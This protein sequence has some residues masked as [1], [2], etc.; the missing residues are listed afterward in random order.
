MGYDSRCY[1]L[2]E[3]FVE[4]D[5]LNAGADA[6]ER[7]KDELAQVIQSAIEDYLEDVQ[8]D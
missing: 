2:A 8:R 3:V 7:V 6:A 4:P 1:D 5:K